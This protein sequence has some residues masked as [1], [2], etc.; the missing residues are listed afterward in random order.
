MGRPLRDLVLV[1]NEGLDR[2]CAA[3]VADGQDYRHGV[4]GSGQTR[5][6]RRGGERVAQRARRK[7]QRLQAHA[8]KNCRAIEIALAVGDQAGKGGPTRRASP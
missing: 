8:A 2:G 3:V 4:H 1:R 5:L 7:D 6:L